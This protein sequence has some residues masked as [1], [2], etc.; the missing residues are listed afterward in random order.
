MRGANYKALADAGF[1]FSAFGRELNVF[2]KPEAE[3]RKVEA[4]APRGMGFSRGSIENSS[5]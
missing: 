4:E 3:R 2:R 1:R 5:A